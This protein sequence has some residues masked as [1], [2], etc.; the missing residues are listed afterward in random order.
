MQRR[1]QFFDDLRGRDPLA[2]LIKR[3]HTVAQSHHFCQLALGQ[4]LFLAQLPQ[5]VSKS[6]HRITPFFLYCHAS[7][8]TVG[9]FH[10]TFG[11]F[12]RNVMV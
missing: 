1:G 8:F 2:D 12:K 9:G 4:L 7:F 5:P 6:H 10:F 11:R 3:N